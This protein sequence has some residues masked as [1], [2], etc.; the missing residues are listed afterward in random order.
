MVYDTKDRYSNPTK[1]NECKSVWVYDGN[2]KFWIRSY[3]IQKIRNS[4]SVRFY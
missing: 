1:C 4:S 2:K 3:K